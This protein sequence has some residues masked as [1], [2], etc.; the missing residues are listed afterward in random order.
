MSLARQLYPNAFQRKYQ[1]IDNYEPIINHLGKPLVHK[2]TDPYQGDALVLLRTDTGYGFLV[3]GY[4]TCSGCDA[5]QACDS[6]ED[7]ESL[8]DNLIASMKTFDTLAD[9]QLHIANDSY[10]KLRYHYHLKE[11]QEFRSTCLSLDA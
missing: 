7:L 1:V 11:W 4:G 10:H 5:L 9:A 6:Y 3:F 8:I 2:D